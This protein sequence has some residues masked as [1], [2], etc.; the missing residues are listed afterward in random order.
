MVLP[1]FHYVAALFHDKNLPVGLRVNFSPTETVEKSVNFFFS[2]RFF[3]GK[4]SQLS[5]HLRI[6]RNRQLL[7]FFKNWKK[8]SVFAIFCC[9]FFEKNTKIA[10]YA[11]K[12]FSDLRI[13]YMWPESK[14]E[15]L[16]LKIPENPWKNVKFLRNFW[17]KTSFFPKFYKKFKK[18]AKCPIFACNFL[19]LKKN[20]KNT[21]NFIF[22]FFFKKKTLFL[23]KTALLAC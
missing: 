9:F 17:K 12:N 14:F 13:R 5:H 2:L 1:R 18:F 8:L 11:S 16:L 3:L 19:S 6:W 23:K 21:K 10:L 22:C 15:N 4:F 7:F 20:K